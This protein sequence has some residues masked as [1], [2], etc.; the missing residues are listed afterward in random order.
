MV[1]VSSFGRPG[2]WESSLFSLV[3][4]DLRRMHELILPCSV[5]DPARPRWGVAARAYSMPASGG[6]FNG[7]GDDFSC[8]G[9][10]M[11]PPEWRGHRSL[12]DSDRYRPVCVGAK[13]SVRTGLALLPRTLNGDTSALEPVLDRAI[14]ACGG[15]VGGS[16]RVGR[17][18]RLGGSGEGERG[19]ESGT[20]QNGSDDETTHEVLLQRLRRRDVPQGRAIPPDPLPI[21]GYF[22]RATAA[23]PVVPGRNPRRRNSAR[24]ARWGGHRRVWARRRRGGCTR[25]CRNGRRANVTGW[26]LTCSYLAPLTKFR[27]ASWKLNRTFPNTTRLCMEFDTD[28]QE[29]CATIHK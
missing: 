26:K 9:T 15:R 2:S 7:P 17:S 21:A 5:A 20:E 8:R 16:G 27:M 13:D 6:S 24:G 28:W 11:P 12:S 14:R 22:V 25:S 10:R 3:H 18:C 23:R 1:V 4:Q 29:P 19:R